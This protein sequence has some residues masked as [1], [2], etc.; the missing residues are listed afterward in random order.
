M[1]Q[2]APGDGR[3]DIVIAN[4]SVAEQLFRNNGD[5]TFTELALEKGAAYNSKGSSFAGMGV[6]W[7]DYD[8][9]GWPDIF[10]NALSLQGYVLLRNTQGEYED[11]SDLTGL[12]ALTMAYGGWGSKFVDCD[13]DTILLK[14]NQIGA[15]ACHE[16]YKSCFF[17]RLDN[18]E[19]TVIGERVFDP[20]QVYK[21]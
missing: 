9:D 19:L 15:A 13:N 14:V 8:N 17:R 2:P 7:N 16:G 21:K 11:V 18:D 5:G 4:D 6:D 12:T 10:L 1:P 3:P 20:K